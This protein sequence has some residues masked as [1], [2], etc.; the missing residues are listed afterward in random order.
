VSDSGGTDEI[1][2]E[3]VPAPQTFKLHVDHATKIEFDITLVHPSATGTDCAISEFEF[4]TK[5]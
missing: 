1:V 4:F 5:H 2:L 3:D